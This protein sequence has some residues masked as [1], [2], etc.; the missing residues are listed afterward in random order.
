[1]IKSWGLGV[2]GHTFNPSTWEAEASLVYRVSSRT[3]RATQRIPV[4]K[5]KKQTNK[6]KNKKTKK[7][8]NKR[9]NKKIFLGLQYIYTLST[10]PRIPNIN[11]LY[12]EESH[13]SQSMRQII[14]S[15]CGQSE[16][17]PCPTPGI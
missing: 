5:N 1:V 9:T 11:D 13:S 8:K 3:A 16:A 17:A 10:V 2:V 15:C 6:Q 7:T 14:V 4:L 12:L